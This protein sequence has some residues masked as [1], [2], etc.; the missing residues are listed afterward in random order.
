MRVCCVY[1]CVRARVRGWCVYVCV[2]VCASAFVRAHSRV[3]IRV[4]A[5]LCV[6]IRACAWLCVRLSGHAQGGEGRGGGRG[7]ATSQCRKAGTSVCRVLLPATPVEPCPF[8]RASVAEQPLTSQCLSPS[9]PALPPSHSREGP[10]RLRLYGEV[11]LQ[12]HADAAADQ[13]LA[14][15]PATAAGA[16]QQ[17]LQLQQPVVLV[18]DA[19]L[20]HRLADA[21]AGQGRLGLARYAL[22]C[23]L[24]AAQGQHVLLWEKLLQVSRRLPLLVW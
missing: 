1:L 22:E 10:L 14:A 4:C 15:R 9:L 3:R 20:W 21:A 6:R 11:V 12:Q 23:G 8:Q 16:V 19:V 17:Q 5:W 13:P 7:T 2:R 18:Q 24:V